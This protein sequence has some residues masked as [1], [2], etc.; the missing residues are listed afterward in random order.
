MKILFAVK[1]GDEAWR[2]QL[3]TED[4]TRIDAA[5]TWAEENGFD[6][7]RVADIDDSKPDFKNTINL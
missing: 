4:E 2:E 3:I 7:I 6:R 1:I 5:K